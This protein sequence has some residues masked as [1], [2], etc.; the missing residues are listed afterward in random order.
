MKNANQVIGCRKAKKGE[1]TKGQ[2]REANGWARKTYWNKS[3]LDRQAPHKS[4]I[5]T[6]GKSRPD[7]TKYVKVDITY[8]EKAEKDLYECG[9]IALKHDKESVIQYVIVK[10][11]TGY[12]KCKK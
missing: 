8:D 10:A 2:S 5:I 4:G 12:A 1:N 3:C 7:P 9:M 6:F 11:L